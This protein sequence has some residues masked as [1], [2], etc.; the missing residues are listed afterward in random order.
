[1]AADLNFERDEPVSNRM[2]FA[3]NF[4]R[5]EA[6]PEIESLLPKDVKIVLQP[7][8]KL[9]QR[10][11]PTTMDEKVPD[12]I[13]DLQRNP[14][15]SNSLWESK[16]RN[17]PSSPLQSVQSK[18]TQ[19]KSDVAIEMIS[20]NEKVMANKTLKEHF[21]LDAEFRPSR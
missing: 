7:N 3:M 1:M 12:S 11:L 20:E 16:Q 4:S 19:D 8:K 6:Q 9:E 17:S 15:N 2:P 5:N 21:R 14:Q 13:L 18:P 10:L